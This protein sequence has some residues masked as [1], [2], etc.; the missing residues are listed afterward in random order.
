MIISTVLYLSESVVGFLRNEYDLGFLPSTS[1]LDGRYHKLKVEVVG[2]EGDLLR[3]TDAKGRRR[4][5][6][7]YARDGY[8]ATRNAR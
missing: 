3:V 6:V 5:I 8:M 1:T 7:V 2:P 4:K